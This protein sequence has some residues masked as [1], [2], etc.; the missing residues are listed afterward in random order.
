MSSFQTSKKTARQKIKE[1]DELTAS[2]V[3][4]IFLRSATLMK[5]NHG[6]KLVILLITKN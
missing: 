5:Q 2:M 4:Y 6:Q 1:K 3:R